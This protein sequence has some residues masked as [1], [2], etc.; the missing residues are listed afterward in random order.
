MD[1][2]SV[3]VRGSVFPGQGPGHPGACA[4]KDTQA[5]REWLG[6]WKPGT[7]RFQD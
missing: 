5:R 6:S 7:Q 3:G 1:L 4:G 2:Q